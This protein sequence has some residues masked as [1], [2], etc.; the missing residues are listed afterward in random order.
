MD[1]NKGTTLIEGAAGGEGRAVRGS[2]L[3]FLNCPVN[4]TLLPHRSIAV[5]GKVTAANRSAN[6]PPHW[7]LTTTSC[8]SHG[9]EKGPAIC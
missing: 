3:H 7:A 2:A 9:S 8:G 5:F 4:P 1:C 6:H